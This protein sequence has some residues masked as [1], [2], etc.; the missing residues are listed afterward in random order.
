MATDLERLLGLAR[1]ARVVFERVAAKDTYPPHLGGLCYD[2]S[3][4]LRRMAAAYG[5]KTDLGQG[6]G[7]WFVLFGNTVV[8][9]TSTQFGQPEKIAVLPLEEAEK[10]G[11][12][13]S[14]VGRHSD[15]PPPWNNRM[16]NM[17]AEEA[18]EVMGLGV[19]ETE[20]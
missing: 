16:A 14:L 2:A 8:D 10:R 5:I 20:L 18:D 4:F 6:H 7:H 13:W 11:H 1:I 15:P 3:C 9:V 17:A 12:W 19:G